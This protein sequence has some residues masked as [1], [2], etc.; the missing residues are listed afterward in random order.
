M[1]RYQLTVDQFNRWRVFDAKDA[2][3]AFDT[4]QAAD[5]FKSKLSA[6]EPAENDAP[7]WTPKSGG[8]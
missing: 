3:G 4:W 6:D 7:A 8:Y 5:E 2:L 1:S